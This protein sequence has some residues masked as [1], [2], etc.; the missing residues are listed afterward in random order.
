MNYT[1]YFKDKHCIITGASSGL[2]KH[3]AIT[4]A[5][6]GVHLLLV[7][8]REKA[9]QDI[10]AQCVKISQKFGHTSII[11]LYVADTSN[12][13]QAQAAITHATTIFPTID[14][15][16]ANAGASMHA[17]IIDAQ[18]IVYKKMLDANFYSAVNIITP[19]LPILRQAHAQGRSPMV[20]GVSS[21]QSVIGVPYHAGYVAAKHAFAGFLEGL[22][23]EEPN[24]Q[25]VELIPGWIKG[26]NIRTAAIDAEGNN[27]ETRAQH[28]QRHSRS[29]VS[30]EECVEA[31]IKGMVNKQRLVFRPKFWRHILLLKYFNRTYLHGLVVKRQKFSS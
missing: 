30:V 4:L 13:I 8:R 15:L 28:T 31:T 5:Q 14:I 25:V 17:S 2:G 21:I 22:E 6:Y 27:S 3:L 23:L 1:R 10:V 20:V 18:E 11:S 9:L 7:A 19:A 12:A 26:T 24:I 16:I 29:S